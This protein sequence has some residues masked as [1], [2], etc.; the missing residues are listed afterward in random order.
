MKKLSL[1]LL[2]VGFVFLSLSFEVTIT[3][4]VIGRGVEVSNVLF[5][6]L[7]LTFFIGSFVLYVVNKSLE[8][9]VIP[10]GNLEEDE[11]RVETAMRSYV[12]TKDKPYVLVSGEIHR[13]ES[14]GPRRESQQYSIYKKLR[15]Q[16]GL[17]PSD[18]IIEGK[19]R[20][21][22]ENF[23]N[24]VEKLKRKGVNHLKIATNQTQYWRFKLFEREAKREG[25]VDGSFEIEPLYTSESPR[26]FVYGVLA[27]VKDY[28]RIKFAGS[29]E[30]AKNQRTGSF[31]NF[32]KNA[33]GSSPE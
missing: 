18:L 22:L 31:G 2:L 23:L 1:V 15:E 13:D 32:F 16:Y 12:R 7:S 30:D 20:D 24:S 19:S 5:F 25:L 17:K 4:A 33:F 14:G 9:L 27:Y 8:S 3:G 11:K 6:I 10:T 21:T 26:E 29:L 28:F